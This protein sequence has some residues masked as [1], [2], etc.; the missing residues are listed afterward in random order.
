MFR[1]MADQ[2]PLIRAVA[3]FD[4]QNLF[5]SAKQAFGYSWPNFDPTLL[6]ERVCQGHGWQLQQTRFYTGVPDAA[7]KPFWNHFWVAKAAQMAR[8]G[9]H[10]YT[11]SLRYRNKKVRLP[12][13]TEHSFLDGDEKGIDVR[14][15]LDVIRLALKREFD[16]AILFCRD[17]DLTEVADEIRLIAQE[18]NRWIKVASAFPVSPTYRVRG[19]DKTDWIKLDRQLYDQCLDSRDYRPKKP[20]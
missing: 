18:Q 17:Q 6:A 9:V 19:I 8:Q 10:V 12:D 15:A 14:I 13:G 4:G 11:R 5:H 2:L 16:V 1:Y 20:S 3:F 7:D